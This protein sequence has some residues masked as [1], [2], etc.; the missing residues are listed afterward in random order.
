MDPME[1][2]YTISDG[3]QPQHPNASQCTDYQRHQSSSSNNF[4]PHPQNAH[5]YDPVYN[6]DSWFQQSRPQFTAPQNISQWG[7]GP[8][9]PISSWQGFGDTYGGMRDDN[10]VYRP[11]TGFAGMPNTSPWSEQ[12]RGHE[13]LPFGYN[14]YLHSHNANPPMG[15]SGNT[16]VSM[17]SAPSGA[18]SHFPQANRFD[19]ARRNRNSLNIPS[20]GSGPNDNAANNEF[21]RTVRTSREDMRI[22]QAQQISRSYDY[23]N[24]FVAHE[25]P[26]L[27]ARRRMPQSYDASDDEDDDSP[28]S[29]ESVRSHTGRLYN[30]A[31]DERA[32]ASMRGGIASGKR[33]PSKEAMASIE[34]VE[35]KD[36]DEKDRSCIICYNDFGVEN[37][38]GLVEQPMRLPTCKHVFG[39]K[40]IKKWFEDSDTCPYCRNKL[41]SERVVSRS[42]TYEAMQARYRERAAALGGSAH[43]AVQNQRAR[44]TFTHRFPTSEDMARDRFGYSRQTPEEYYLMRSAQ[45]HDSWS[46]SPPS[47]RPSQRDSPE[48]RRQQARGRASS[49]RPTSVGSARFSFPSSAHHSAVELARLRAMEGHTNATHRSNTPGLVRQSSDISAA[50]TQGPVDSTFSEE[51]SPAV[52][53][54]SAVTVT[55]LTSSSIESRHNA[56]SDS[57]WQDPFGQALSQGDRN[58]YPPGRPND[59]PRAVSFESRTT[60]SSPNGQHAN[61][62]MTNNQSGDLGPPAPFGYRHLR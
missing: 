30:E 5:H 14:Q 18:A 6:T 29:N 56:L 43:A 61:S 37:P 33:V 23:A 62:E 1:Y 10:S 4:P 27:N 31:E 13:P 26:L 38:E 2:E 46:F 20:T 7:P 21:S 47:S 54:G 9:V 59:F 17:A 41:P 60:L 36:L 48:R 42:Y 52:V 40:C 19:N 32:L 44:H 35:I 15:D 55:D 22:A 25:T 11:T 53:I 8:H 16:R 49:G 3:H 45:Q 12:L 58:P 50:A 57:L 51:T 39:D 34:K 24:S 28:D